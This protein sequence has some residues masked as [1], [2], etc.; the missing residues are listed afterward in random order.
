MPHISI[1]GAGISG[2]SAAC[3]AAAAGHTV[4]VYE[5]NS[6]IGGRARAFDQGGF[7]FDMGP[8][9]YWM[10]DIFERFFNDFGK[11]T[12]DM[13][14]L[15]K[16]DP[17]FRVFFA[18]SAPIDIPAGAGELEALFESIEP[19]SSAQLRSYL[20]D[21]E[22]KYRH[23]MLALA[24]RPSLSWLEFA[25]MS[26]VKNAARL[27]MFSSI[28][29]HVRSYFKDP[30]LAAIMEFPSLFLGAMPDNIPA[31]YS[32][33]NYAAL[34]Q[35]TWYPMGGMYK[36]I[37]AMESIA[38]SLGV[39]FHTDCP[40]E[41]ITTT[42]GKTTGLTAKQQQHACDAIIA[43]GDYHHIEQ[44]LL[45]P[46][47]RNYSAAYWDKKTFAPSC[48]IF[49]LG[50]DRKLPGLIHHNLFFDAD[51]EQHAAEIYRSPAWPANPLFYVCCP[52][53]TD[54]SVAP[55]GH[56][57]L[58]VLV[59]VATRL[60]DD[61]QLH[62]HY[63]NLVMDRIEKKIGASIRDHIIYKR[64]YSIADFTKDYNAYGGNAYGLANTL[65]QTA[66]LKPK[67]RNKN[68]RN[69]FYAG[70][71]TVPGPGV[72]PCIISGQLAAMQAIKHLNT[73]THESAI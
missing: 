19:G 36:V 46:T 7:T 43:T 26:L 22:F 34:A 70:Q 18:G 16:L 1:I 72:P 67:L 44:Q 35:G 32:L 58:F 33:M 25:D 23:G 45:Q 2:I 8:S 55:G 9:W 63:Y 66:V 57:N 42:N 51:M 12:A 49:Y 10:P 5:K 31:L 68:I 4:S 27:K 59:P 53:K 64:T 71:L 73:K 60:Q 62:E 3:Y 47:L 56:E 6:T 28:R 14:N 69:L 30:R 24:Y 65:M 40:V 54:R 37:E 20:A 50:V 29:S 15:V 41:S 21:A 17:G 48:L 39:T 11:T 61:P 38:L 13:L 52:S